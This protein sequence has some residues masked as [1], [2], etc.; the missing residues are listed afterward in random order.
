MKVKNKITIET[1]IEVAEK[2]EMIVKFSETKNETE[3]LDMVAAVV[4]KAFGLT[5]NEKQ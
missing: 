4:N 1:T 2:D 3:M 5:G